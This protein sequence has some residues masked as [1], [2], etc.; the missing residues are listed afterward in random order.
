MNPT[1]P[2]RHV[3]PT[4]CSL[5]GISV[6][7]PSFYAAVP[8]IVWPDADEGNISGNERDILEP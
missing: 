8:E 1:P 2:E 4:V 5:E 6:Y 3:L 7:S